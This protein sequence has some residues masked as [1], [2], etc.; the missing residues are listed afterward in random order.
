VAQAVLYVGNT[1]GARIL[2]LRDALHESYLNNLTTVTGSVRTADGAA[3]SPAVNLTFTYQAGT[4]GEYVAA[5]PATA[6]ILAGT[7]Y[8]IHV[9][10]NGGAD[11]VGSFDF[12][13]KAETRRE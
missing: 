1:N 3:L 13:A 12:E 6:A 2:G 7:T 5:I 4:D 10:V 8:L 9:D 11:L